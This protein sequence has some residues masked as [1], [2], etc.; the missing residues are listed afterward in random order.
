MKV[1]SAAPARAGES[2]GSVTRA[3]VRHRPVPRLAEA[4]R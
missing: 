1:S 2:S 4:S 3:G